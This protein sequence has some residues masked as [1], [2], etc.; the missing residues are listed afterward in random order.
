MPKFFAPNIDRNGRIV[1]ATL[2]TVLVIGGAAALF[3]RVWAGITLL[4]YGAFVLFE[5]WRGWCVMRACG[6]KTKM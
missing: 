2:G 3:W 5:A 6:I 1:R 4:A